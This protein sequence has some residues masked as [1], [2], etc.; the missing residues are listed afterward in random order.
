MNILGIGG[1]LSDAA[2]A[3]IQDGRI[4]A[5]IEETKLTRRAQAGQLPQA[6]I[7]SC[8]D[9]AG[10]RAGDIDYVALARPLPPGSGLAASLRQFSRARVVSIDHHAAHA[11]S[12][13]FLS[14]FENATIIT[15]DRAGDLRCGGKWRGA[16]N[17]IV[18]EEEILYPDSIAELYGR[19]TELLGFRQR[20]DEHM[21]Q[22]LSAT[23]E[24]KYAAAFGEIA[25]DRSIDQSYFDS[26]R[27][28]QGGFGARFFER[29]GLNGNAAIA[30]RDRADIAASMQKTLEDYVLRLAGDDARNVCIAGGVAW[31]ALLISA[32][33]HS[34]RFEGV[35]AQPAAGNAGTALGAALNVWHEVLGESARSDGDGYCFGPEFGVGETKQTLEN[36]KLR[37]RLLPTTPELI[38]AAVDELR[39][40]KIVAWMQGRMEFGPRALGNR[41]I[42]ASPQDP[43]S[44]ENLN[45]FIKHRESFRKFAASVPAERASEFF[46]VGSNARHLATAGRVR[47]K[48]KDQ[49]RGAILASDLIRVHTVSRDD[50][51]LYWQ[52]LHAFGEKTGLPVLY[53]TSFNLFGEPL[54][55][56]PRD[57][58]RSFYSSGI[59]AMVVG[60]FLLKK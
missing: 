35:F 29:L 9:I 18:L 1:V 13:Y 15:L 6:A 46:E 16:G 42:L 27:Q 38:G 33:E 11:A 55:C 54:V 51:P 36:C 19:V 24:P 25:R 44:T 32:L 20:A 10:L 40:D 37:F 59:D 60:N 7:A 50:N 31:N 41:S 56:T 5:A 12:A 47:A 30:P 34:G 3:L 43:Y 22:W 2:A 28:G 14:P 53:N 49:F 26:G 4:A 45:T 23:G 52:L 58:V 8:L 39:D 48:Y 57:A 17:R 21:V